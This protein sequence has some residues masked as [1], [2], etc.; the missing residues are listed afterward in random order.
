MADDKPVYL[1]DAASTP[2]DTDVLYIVQG[3]GTL[4]RKITWLQL[5]TLL[6]G[7]APSAGSVALEDGTSILLLEDG[8]SEL[9][10]EP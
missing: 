7:A 5:R 9:L 2:D 10:L 8:T 3:N 6:G 1:M 4:D